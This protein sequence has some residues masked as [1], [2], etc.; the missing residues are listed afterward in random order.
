MFKKILVPLDGSHRAEKALNLVNFL[1][2]KEDIELI[3]L[4]VIESDRVATPAYVSGVDAF[5]ELMIE[6]RM[7]NAKAYISKIAGEERH[8]FE[9]IDTMIVRGEP[10]QA[11]AHVAKE[12]EV[13]LIVMVTNGYSRIERWFRSSVTEG[14]IRQAACPVLAILDDRIPT[15]F[16]APLDG[17][18]FSEAGLDS[19]LGLA[20]LFNAKVTLAKV[21]HP[22]DLVSP[23]DVKEIAQL[24]R[25]L[26]ERIIVESS[27]QSEFYLDDLVRDKKKVFDVEINYDVDQGRPAARII[28]MAARNKCDLIAMTTHGR[29]GIDRLLNGS[30]TETVFRTAGCDIFVTHSQAV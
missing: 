29:K 21:D 14:V 9:K 3:L 27:S 13:D 23:S 20:K 10:S 2:I 15:H 1:S 30:V 16:L 5:P 24:D 28:A 25:E 6:T 4:D 22:A 12:Q 7:E 18:E 8:I 11:I 17:T 19:A 26:A